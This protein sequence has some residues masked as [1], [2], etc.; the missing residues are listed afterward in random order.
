MVPGTSGSQGLETLLCHRECIYIPSKRL[1]VAVCVLGPVQ[2]WA[3]RSQLRTRA[4]PGG[5][6]GGELGLALRAGCRAAEN[7]SDSYQTASPGVW[8]ALTPSFPHKDQ[9]WEGAAMSRRAQRS[10]GLGIATYPATAGTGRQDQPN[11]VKLVWGLM[12]LLS[13]G[14]FTVLTWCFPPSRLQ[15]PGIAAH[16]P[17]VRKKLPCSGSSLLRCHRSCWGLRVGHWFG[18]GAELLKLR[19][20]LVL[21][22]RDPRGSWWW[23]QSLVRPHEPWNWL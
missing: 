15:A 19:L 1:L 23:Q 20:L 10:S 14:G 8:V 16:P 4:A 2:V 22:R 5:W 11:W 6:H 3:E 17:S 7:G 9:L 12:M 13:A 18:E 21:A